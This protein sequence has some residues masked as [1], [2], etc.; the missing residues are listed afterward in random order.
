[1]YAGRRNKLLFCIIALVLVVCSLFSAVQPTIAL[2]S[3]REVSF[4]ET[5]VLDDL[6]SSEGFNILDYPYSVTEDKV[7]IINFVEYYYSY[8]AN[9]QD[10]YGLYIYLYNPTGKNFDTKSK[11][12]MIEMATAYDSNGRP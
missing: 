4:D 12:N 7:R 6:K 11:A 1:M 3:E 9:M 5:N 10:N 2:A 8:K